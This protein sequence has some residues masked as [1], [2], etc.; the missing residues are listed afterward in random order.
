MGQGLGLPR[1]PQATP[2]SILPWRPGRASRGGGP[3]SLCPSI[4]H[5]PRR[6]RSRTI[7]GP[8]RWPLRRR[9]GVPRE[10]EHPPSLAPEL[11]HLPLRPQEKPGP[12][13]SHPLVFPPPTGTAQA[14]QSEWGFHPEGAIAKARGP[15]AQNYQPVIGQ[16]EDLSKLTFANY[17]LELLPAGSADPPI[18]AH[19]PL[20]GHQSGSSQ[21]PPAR[22]EA[23]HAAYGGSPGHWSPCREA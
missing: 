20:P 17:N 12:V 21:A 14:S 11:G 2:S 3:G 10:S 6:H 22:E 8:R 5:R 7:S 19:L 18:R 15:A 23:T 13:P 1:P 4:R 16:S 9:D